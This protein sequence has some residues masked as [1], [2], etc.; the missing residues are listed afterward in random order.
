MQTS[1]CPADHYAEGIAPKYVPLRAKQS[2]NCSRGERKTK[3]S[4]VRRQQAGQRSPTQNKTGDK[5]LWRRRPVA[6]HSLFYHRCRC[7]R[8]YLQHGHGDG[9]AGYRHEVSLGPLLPG[10]ETAVFVDHRAALRLLPNRK[11][12]TPPRDGSSVSESRR[13]S[14]EARTE[15]RETG[16]VLLGALLAA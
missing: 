4:G 3:N 10:A 2:K 15:V 16:G 1:I 14:R 12:A 5:P 6:E 13:A 11:F 7:G 9:G 8:Q